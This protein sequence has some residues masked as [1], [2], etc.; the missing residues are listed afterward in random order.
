MNRDNDLCNGCKLPQNNGIHKY[1]G[2]GEEWSWDS[3][4]E[5]K[6]TDAFGELEFPGSYKKRAKVQNSQVF[7]LK[8]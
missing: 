1:D 5:T 2:T 7:I 6:P 3:C 4:T 8:N